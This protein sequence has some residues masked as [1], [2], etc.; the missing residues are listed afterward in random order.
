LAG[1][2]D[3]SHC[4]EAMYV[5]GKYF[6][7]IGDVKLMR[8]CFETAADAGHIKSIYAMGLHYKTSFAETDLFESYLIYAAEHGHIEAMLTIA[9]YYAID[10]PNPDNMIHYYK[11]AIKAGNVYAMYCLGQYYARYVVMSPCLLE[12]RPTK[13]ML[14]YYKLAAEANYLPAVEELER[15]YRNIGDFAS[16][17]DYRMKIIDSGDAACIVRLMSSMTS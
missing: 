4:P 12:N 6:E 16:M 2:V 17:H 15:Y 5:R 13:K 10:K 11:M 8:K 14:K 1:V 9:K 3:D 7:S